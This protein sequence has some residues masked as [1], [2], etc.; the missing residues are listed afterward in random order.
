MA[1]II[2]MH[3]IFLYKRSLRVTT[4][5]LK[6]QNKVPEVSSSGRQRVDVVS[7]PSVLWYLQMATHV[8]CAASEG[9]VNNRWEDHVTFLVPEGLS[10]FGKKLVERSRKLGLVQYES[11]DREQEYTYDDVTESLVRSTTLD[12]WRRRQHR[13][14]RSLCKHRALRRQRP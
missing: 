3:D 5:V 8:G 7:L 2:S 12:F 6:C 13:L 1:F 11:P 14:V 4:L 9:D 10:D